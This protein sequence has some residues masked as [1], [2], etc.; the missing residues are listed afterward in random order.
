MAAAHAHEVESG[1]AARQQPTLSTS[2]ELR[3]G[4]K[5]RLAALRAVRLALPE[6]SILFWRGSASRKLVIGR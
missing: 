3:G 2:L 6:S 5:Q 4:R 1:D